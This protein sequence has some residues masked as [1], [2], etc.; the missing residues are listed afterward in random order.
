MNYY[1]NLGGIIICGITGVSDEMGREINAYDSIGMGKFSVPDTAGLR[2]WTIECQLTEI[3]KP[4]VRNWTAARKIFAGFDTLLNTKNPSR[5]IFTSQYRTDSLSAYLRSYTK[6]EKFPG[7]YDVSIQVVEYKPVGIKTTEVPY[8]QRPGKVPDPPKVVVLNNKTTPYT[9]TRKGGGGAPTSSTDKTGG[10]APSNET[11][12]GTGN[13]NENPPDESNDK[14]QTFPR[15][16]RMGY[17]KK[18]YM[19]CLM[20][21]NAA[22]TGPEKAFTAIKNTLVRWRTEEIARREQH[23]RD[24]A[25]KKVR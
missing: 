5:F 22:D 1:V 6:T 17:D 12:P 11:A 3:N 9:I 24:I 7:V 13:D 15:I 25:I 8:I 19:D 10:N 21:R 23:E 16:G 20:G 4:F 18:L 14:V 2:T